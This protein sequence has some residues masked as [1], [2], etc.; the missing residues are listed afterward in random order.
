MKG[1]EG[2]ASMRDKKLTLKWRKPKRP[3][4]FPTWVADD[5]VIEQRGGF[6]EYSVY[7][8]RDSKPPH[9]RVSVGGC[10]SLAQAKAQ[11][12]CHAENARKGTEVSTDDQ[13]IPD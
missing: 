4:A 10:N 3:T 5:Y 12:R 6:V 2:K 11:A 8:P 1:I 9:Y 13:T 7:G